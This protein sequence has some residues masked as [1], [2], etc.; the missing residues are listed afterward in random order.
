MAECIFQPL[1]QRIQQAG[2]RI[3]GGQF[4][5]D[6]QVST[7][8]H[9]EPRG[10]ALCVYTGLLQAPSPGLLYQN[11]VAARSWAWAC[12]WTRSMLAS[13]MQL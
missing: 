13:N 6:V 11:D 4:V 12:C 3:V 10:L 7:C 5:T 9:A 1:I 8:P 2:G